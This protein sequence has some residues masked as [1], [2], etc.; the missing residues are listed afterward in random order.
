MHVSFVIIVLAFYDLLA[1]IL[2]LKE[3]ERQKEK[4]RKREK[5]YYAVCVR[6]SLCEEDDGELVR[7]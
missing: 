5:R 3:K 2:R 7:E 6:A 1:R 4:I